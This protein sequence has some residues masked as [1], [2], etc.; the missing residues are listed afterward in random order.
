MYKQKSHTKQQFKQNFLMTGEVWYHI[1][2]DRTHKMT[3]DA[4]KN[5]GKHDLLSQ[6][7]LVCSH[8]YSN[9]ADSSDLP[10]WPAL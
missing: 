9:D 2:I 10:K 3:S 4:K 8:W 1:S 5:V 7:L 6:M